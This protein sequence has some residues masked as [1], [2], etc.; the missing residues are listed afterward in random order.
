MM[1][2]VQ[3]IKD[4]Y[5]KRK[6]KVNPPYSQYFSQQREREIKEAIRKSWTTSLINKRILDVGCGNGAIL[7][8]FLNDGVLPENLYGIDLLPERIGEA[9]RI[10]PGISFICGNAERLPYPDEFFDIITQSTVFTSIM[11]TRMKKAI[12]AEMVRVLKLDGTIIW[13]D[14]RF[15]N[16]FNPNVKGIGK[17]EIEDLFQ[18]CQFDFKLISLNP[19]IARPLTRFSWRLCEVLEKIPILRTHWLVSIKKKLF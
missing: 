17:R 19:F 3:R 18:G 4:A 14:Y 16:P 15:D 6:I 5:S 13:H 2:E 10:Y 7:S 12:A 1:D 11:D 8:Y 9:K